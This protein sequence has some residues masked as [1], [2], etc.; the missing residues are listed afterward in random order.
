MDTMQPCVNHNGNYDCTPFCRIC[1]GFQYMYTGDHSRKGA[2]DED[3][4]IWFEC[5]DHG[6]GCNRIVC[7]DCN[8]VLVNCEGE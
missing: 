5:R 7:A 6:D 2:C 8:S 1:E 4:A 3:S